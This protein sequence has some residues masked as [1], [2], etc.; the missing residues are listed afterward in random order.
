[1]PA[2]PIV[3]EH[4]I[5]PTAPTEP[6]PAAPAVEPPPDDDEPAPV[7][8]PDTT[9]MWRVHKCQRSVLYP[10]YPGAERDSIPK[11]EQFDCPECG[12]FREAGEDAANPTGVG[13]NY[14]LDEKLAALNKR[15][16]SG[17]VCDTRHRNAVASS[18]LKLSPPAP[19][20]TPRSI[21]SGYEYASL[22][23]GAL[24]LQPADEKMLVANGLVVPERLQYG[25]FVEAYYDVHRGQLPVYVS[26]DSI[27]H[28]V[29]ASHDQLLAKI[30]ENDML[31]RLDGLLGAMHCG[32]ASAAKQYPPE[33]ANDVDLYLTV[34]RTLLAGQPVLSELGKVDARVAELVAMI[35]SPS[36]IET[37]DLFGRARALDTTAFTPRGHYTGGLETYFRAASWLSRVDLNLVSRDT[38]ASHPGYVPDPTE[39]PREAVVALALADLAKRTRSLDDIA[40]LDRA[41]TTLAGARED[42]SFAE[43]DALRSKAKIEKLSLE[44]APALRT[45]IG[46]GWKRTVNTG[47][48]PNVE[49]LPVISTLLG[50]R[51]TPDTVAVGGL[52]AERGP[53]SSGAELGFMLGMDR[54]RV[55]VGSA[56]VTQKA[57]TAARA[58]LAASKPGDDLYSAW[59]S[60]IRS[61]AIKPAGA[62]PSFMDTGAFQDLRLNTVLTAY[63]QLRHNHVLIAAQAYDEGGCEIPDGYVEPAP[64]TYASLAEYAKRGAKVMRSLDPRNRTGG[65]AYYK[66]LEKLMRVL[67]AISKE[68]LAG[69]PLSADTKRFLSM[70]VERRVATANS[71][72]GSYPI[73]TFDGWYLDLFPNIDTALEATSFVADWATYDRD[74]ERGI[75]YLGAK[76]PRLGVF[77]VDTGGKPRLMVGPVAQ[78]FQHEAAMD[79]RLTDNDAYAVEGESPWAKSYTVA[80][81]ALPAFKMSFRRGDATFERDMMRKVHDV[82]PVDVVRI[83]SDMA[84]G[85]VVVE[86][87]DHHFVEMAELEVALVKG[88]VDTRTPKTP[89]PIEALRVRRGTAV[90]RFDVPL[91]GDGSWTVGE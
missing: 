73:A 35:E 36:T 49:R 61:L 8:N 32:L 29:Y 15:R 5:A 63:G 48:T 2:P 40:V 17:G 27:M 46:H 1:M 83:E 87:L 70:I 33:I 60:A 86:L 59:L 51:I 84:R 41:W 7:A 91:D 21:A 67:V 90:E 81:T 57:I 4:T 52:I 6:P 34:A 11:E 79:V 38:R 47:P 68:E 80:A 10:N 56:P 76:L 20:A 58:A 26:V 39:T 65:S 53:D 89:R 82:V 55:Y 45:A 77:V 14:T 12:D 62:T 23:R 22:V 78:G 25:N 16:T 69:K 50:P 24:A 64:D 43:L 72:S 71:Y 3:V 44:A 13:G 28:A 30:E 75:H 18:I 74:G 88:R 9:T 37:I 54:A 66:R 85:D 19:K 31:H 42:V